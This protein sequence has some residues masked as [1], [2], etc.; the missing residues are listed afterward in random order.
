MGRLSGRTGMPFGWQNSAAELFVRRFAPSLFF[1]H[2][3]LRQDGDMLALSENKDSYNRRYHRH[4]LMNL[5]LTV[6]IASLLSVAWRYQT[7]LSPMYISPQL[8]M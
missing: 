2:W 7:D 4:L 6:R 3:H 1:R 5:T 8:I